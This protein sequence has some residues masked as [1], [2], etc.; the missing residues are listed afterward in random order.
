MLRTPAR[1]CQGVDRAELE[2]TSGTLGAKRCRISFLES[3]S[4][5]PA[6]TTTSI[7]LEPSEAK[8]RVK[9]GPIMLSTTV[10]LTRT[11]LKLTLHVF[12]HC[13]ACQVGECL[14]K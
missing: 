5:C 7:W 3:H 6:N 9:G 8:P 1:K 2:R 4:D 10:L 12:G 14:S 13:P 11:V